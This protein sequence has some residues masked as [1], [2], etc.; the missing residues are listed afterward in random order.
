MPL[1]YKVMPQQAVGVD[2]EKE[3]AIHTM[4]DIDDKRVRLID[5]IWKG[6]GLPT[7]MPKVEPGVALPAAI[8]DL[9]GVRQTT[10]LTIPLRYGVKATQYLLTPTKV[11]TK[12]RLAIYHTG[13]GEN[14]IIRV[15]TVQALLDLG[16]AVLCSDMPFVGW[17]VQLIQDL[18]DPKK[19][20]DISSGTRAHNRFDT[21]ETSSFSAMTFFLEPLAVGINYAQQLLRPQSISMIGL[22]GGG[23]TTTAYAAIDTRITRSYP[24]AG[25]FPFYLRPGPSRESTGDWEQG[26]IEGASVPGFY[27]IVSFGDLYVMGAVGPR[28]AQLQILNRFDYCCFAGVGARSYAPVVSH[29]VA[30]IGQ[31]T[32]DLLEDATHNQ[33]QVSPYALEVILWDLETNPPD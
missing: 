15:R 22:S 23:W 2:L 9:T 11:G 28:R 26:G 10:K 13:H 25:T 19:Y 20:V 12:L 31:G 14:P 17:N 29:R 8:A 18:N 32:W 21:Y 16:Y 7:T 27:A 3:I 6:A 24:T 33:H 30:L 4:A 5:Y 1:A